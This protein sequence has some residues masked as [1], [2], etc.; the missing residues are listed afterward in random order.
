MKNVNTKKLVLTALF[1]ALT[2]VSTLFIRI[3]LPLG[4][5]NLGDA[6]VLLSVFILGPILGT[7]AAGIGSTLADVFGYVTYAPG[8][9]IIKTAMAII[10]YLIYKLMLK[11]TK[12]QMLSEI[13]SGLIGAIV[14]TLGYFIYETLFFTTAI[15]AIANAPW[16]LIQGVI[17]VIISTVIMKILNTTNLFKSSQN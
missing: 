15:V 5:V 11:S 13:V 17:G 1:T 8:T 10:T 14:M 2:T 3:P 4:Y 16:N 7:I 9:L 6:F 12:K